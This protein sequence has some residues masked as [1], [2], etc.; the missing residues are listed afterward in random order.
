MVTGLTPNHGSRNGA[1]TVTITGRGFTGATEVDFGTKALLSGFTV[2]ND[3]TITV[4]S[5]P[6]VVPGVVTVTVKV[7]ANLSPANHP[8]DEYVYQ[9]DWYCYIPYFNNQ[10][11]YDVLVFDGTLEN[12][13]ASISR[14][15]RG[16]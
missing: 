11:P 7:G 4:A 9:G 5:T 3:T 1:T 2:V 15:K 13:V 12:Q 16:Q 10:N 8:Y 14:R 6:I